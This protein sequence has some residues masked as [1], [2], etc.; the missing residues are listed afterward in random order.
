MSADLLDIGDRVVAMAGPGEQVEA[1][2]SRGRDTEIKAY[3]GEIESLSS[4]QSQ[5]VGIRVIADGRQGFAYA[6]TFDDD[7][8]AETLAE[9]RDNAG[10]ATPDEFLGLA[11]PDGVAVAELDLFSEAL[12]AL[13]HRRARSSWPSSSSG[14]CAP[15]T[16]ASRASSRPST[17][18]S[19]PRAPSCRTTGIRTLGRETACYVMTYAMA[20]EGDETQTGFGFSVGRD[21]DELD[22][23]HA[24]A[25]TPPSGP[26]ACSARS[27]PPS[28]RLT[29]V[30]DPWV[31]AQFLGILAFTLNGEAVLKGRSLF[32]DRLGDEVASP[33]VTLVDDPTNPEAF[34]ATETDGEGLATRRNVLIEGGVLKLFVQNAYTRPPGRHPRPPARPCA[35]GSRARPASG[36]W[37]RRWRPAPPPRPSWWP[38]SA[39]GLL[40]QDVAGLHS[41]VNPISGDFSTG[42]EGLRIRGGELAEPVREFTIASTLQKMLK[43]V[44]AVG[45]DLAV[46]AHERVGREPGHR[47]GH[48]LR[49]LTDRSW[50]CSTWPERVAQQA[51]PGEQV[52]AYV[53]RGVSTQVKAYGGEVESLTSAESFGVGIRVIARPSPGLRPRRHVRRVGGARDAGRGPRQRVVRRA[54][55]VVRPGRAR[56]RRAGRPGPVARRAGDVRPRRP[57]STW[58]SPSSGPCSGRDPRVTGVRTAIYA[59]SAGE[60]AVASSTGVTAYGR[61]TSCWLS[62]SALADD[63]TETKIGGGID[64]GREPGELD[65]EVA[66][67][68]AVDQGRAPVR[69]PGRCRRSACPSCSS[70]GW[71]PPS[72]VWPAAPSPASAC[73]RAAR[74]SP[75]AWARPSPRRCSPC[76]TTPPTR[77]RWPPRATT[78]R[79]W[80]VA[81]TS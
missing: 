19:W 17:S 22:V 3:E 58:P 79:A 80:P 69:G 34:T 36:A 43:D 10:F 62:V 20:V 67:E 60:G 8:L 27:S 49:C 26:P 40:V 65:V 16:P 2:V 51:G 46:A 70:P 28:E 9:A 45:N 11:E 61:G 71:P 29:V 56:R 12:E 59:D 55:R 78:A 50:T 73:S 76:S 6:A 41:G 75:T 64:V 68:D 72:S 4:A 66:A 32:A 13:P 63:G 39:T 21:P 23:A 31:T 33:L 42:A 1:V 24:A 44:H 74:R 18:T 38:A 52:E 15:P 81:P 57:R 5:G 54:G 53:A 48:H 30:L 47:R 7:V 77:R 37:P 25:P 35:A 14:R